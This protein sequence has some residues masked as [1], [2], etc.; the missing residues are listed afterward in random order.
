[1][2]NFLMMSIVAIALY[3]VVVTITTKVSVNAIYQAG[4]GYGSTDTEAVIYQ[5]SPG[6]EVVLPTSLPETGASK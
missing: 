1:M 4:Y 5:S 3:A 2:K 6:G